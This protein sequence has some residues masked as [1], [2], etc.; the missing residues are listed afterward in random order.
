LHPAVY[1]FEP[2]AALV[3]GELTPPTQVRAAA[4]VRR[5]PAYEPLNSSGSTFR[6]IVE[7]VAA[8]TT[9]LEMSDC[10]TD[11]L[12]TTRATGRPYVPQAAAKQ[13]EPF[14]PLRNAVVRCIED[15]RIERVSRK[16]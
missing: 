4:A 15:V 6:E 8:K 7:L 14:S 16:A 13:N 3:A 10:V 5:D 12:P 1:I 2:V 11:G 9:D